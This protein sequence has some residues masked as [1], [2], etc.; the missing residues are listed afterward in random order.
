MNIPQITSIDNAL[1]I[2]Y[3]HSEIGN[4]EIALLFGRHS[5]A[6]A[7]KLKKVVKNEMIKRNEI[8]YGLYKVKTGT[9]FDVWGIDVSDLEKRRKKLQALKLQ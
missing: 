1:K 3:T 5:S 2:Y 8:S 4:K 9:A 7:A 6:T